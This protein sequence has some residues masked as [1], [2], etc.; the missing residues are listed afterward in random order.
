MLIRLFE[1][2]FPTDKSWHFIT[3]VLIYTVLTVIS[4]ITN[5][6]WGFTITKPYK[7]LIVVIFGFGKEWIWDRYKGGTVDE[8]DAL[9]T[10]IGG[11]CCFINDY[12]S[13]Y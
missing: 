5:L 6:L 8:R 2:W 3:G 10:I 4:L 7:I 13:E 9:Y 12:A 1:K 11:V